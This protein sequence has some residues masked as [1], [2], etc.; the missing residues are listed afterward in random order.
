MS[1]SSSTV[2]ERRDAEPIVG[3]VAGATALHQVVGDW[4]GY[5]VVVNLESETSFK[6]SAAD[7]QP[8][9]AHCGSGDLLFGVDPDDNEDGTFV[10]EDCD[11]RG[12]CPVL[13]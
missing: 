13:S 9:C 3:R 5:L 11:Y 12:L 2:S 10:C 6:V 4:R 7:F 1:S 8:A